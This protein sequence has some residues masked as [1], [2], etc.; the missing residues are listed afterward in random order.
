MALAHDL[1]A[2]VAAPILQY[3]PLLSDADLIEIIACAQVREVLTAIAGR[4]PVSE[5]VSDKL[6]QS[7]DVSAVAAL[8]VN[9]DAIE[10]KISRLAAYCG[11]APSFDAFLA[12][13]LDLRGK[14]G[15]PHTLAEFKVDDKQRELIGEMAIVDPTAGGNP[16]E[17]TKDRA[18]EVFDRAMSGRL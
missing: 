2:V 1:T 7:L 13:V 15:V 8:L 12:T 5:D 6:V 17:L 3:S 16:I 4:K 14:L 18:L 9:R 10:V 11:L